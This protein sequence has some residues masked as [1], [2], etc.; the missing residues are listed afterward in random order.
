LLGEIALDAAV[1]SVLY[2]RLSRKE[3]S[4]WASTTVKHTW[5]PAIVLLCFVAVAG[6]A[7]EEVAP[8]ARSIGGVVRALIE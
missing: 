6:Y 7:M 3:P 8:E 5:M 4:H 1:V 2:R